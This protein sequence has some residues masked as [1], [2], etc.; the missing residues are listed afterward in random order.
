MTSGFVII[1][2]TLILLDIAGKLFAEA[3]QSRLQGVTKEVWLDSQ[4]GFWRG[5]GCIDMIFCAWQMVKI[6][7]AVEHNT[8]IFIDL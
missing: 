1:E 8:K 5:R 3:I 6:H 2:G 7:V 4:C